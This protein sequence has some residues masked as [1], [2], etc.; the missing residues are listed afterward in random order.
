VDEGIVRC[1]LHE[2]ELEPV[3]IK[4]T[5]GTKD[6]WRHFASVRGP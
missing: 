1:T 3:Y 2:H 6:V 4:A 5:A